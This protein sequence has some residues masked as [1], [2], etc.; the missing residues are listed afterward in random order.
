VR[1]ENGI[2]IHFNGTERRNHELTYK[3][4]DHKAFVF[5]QQNFM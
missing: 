5:A 1:A 2:K 3:K 4:V